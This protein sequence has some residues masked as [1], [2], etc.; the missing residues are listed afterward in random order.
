V[1]SSSDPRRNGHGDPGSSARQPSRRR[2][3]R[4]EVRHDRHRRRPGGPRG[5]LL[6][7]AKRQLFRDPRRERADRRLV[8]DPYLELAPPVHAC[9][10]RRPAGLAVPCARLVVS[11]RAR[12]RR[13]P[14]GLCGALR[15]SGSHRDDRRPALQ[16]R[17]RLRRRMRR[18]PVRGRARGR[19]DRLL[20]DA[21]GPRLRSGARPADRADALQRIPRSL[22]A[23]SRRRS[24][25]RGRKLGSRYRDGGVQDSP[26]LALRTGQ[27]AGADSHREQ[28]GTVRPADPLVRRLACA[29]GEDADR[30]QGPSARPRERGSTDPGQGGR[31]PG[32]GRRT[33]AEDY[34]RDRRSA[35]APASGRISAGSTSLFS[36]RTRR[37]STTAASRPSQA[38]ISSAWISCTPSPRRTS[39]A[40]TETHGTSPSKSPR[41]RVEGCPPKPTKS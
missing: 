16:E 12:D 22:P 38:C 31:S 6:P 5:R 35:G 41:G 34:W 3:D 36:A 8:A 17:R 14:R 37:R 40:S 24:P 7:E 4:R 27:R 10:L 30:P 1:Y 28:A 18:A 25:G 9:A 32:G 15:A 20:R 21:F 39:A 26:N 2:P 13:L 19:C 11:D 29:H 23:P 33:G